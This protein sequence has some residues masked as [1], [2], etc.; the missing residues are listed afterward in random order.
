[1]GRLPLAEPPH[2]LR[3]QQG[4]DPAPRGARERG[5]VNIASIAV[6]VASPTLPACAAAKAG[7]TSLTK[8]LA[9]EH[10]SHDIRV[11]AIGPG[12]LWTRRPPQSTARWT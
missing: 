11:N 8:S 4:R 7:V 5:H 3:D 10:A 9:L 2:D 6:L 12:F 1:V